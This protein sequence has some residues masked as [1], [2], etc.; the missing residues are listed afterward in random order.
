MRRDC[1]NFL[2]NSLLRGDVA[3]APMKF[4]Q[5]LKD[6]LETRDVSPT[7]LLASYPDIKQACASRSSDEIVS[8]FR[9]RAEEYECETGTMSE[10]QMYLTVV[11]LIKL[12]KR[13]VDSETLANALKVHAFPDSC[14]QVYKALGLSQKYNPLKLLDEKKRI[15][16]TFGTFDLFH[17]GHLSILQRAKAMGDVLVVGVSSDE[18]NWAKKRKR[19]CFSFEERRDIVR[20]IRCVDFVFKEESLEQKAEYLDYY[21]VDT[22]VMGDDWVGRF[23]HLGTSKRN[24]RY[25]GRTPSISTTCI[26]ELIQN[27]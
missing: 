20:N 22:L 27:A 21:D 15:V 8:E 5:I 10:A 23:D 6:F 14:F 7:E 25:L 17:V 24:V 16:M 4:R 12:F 13:H 9:A 2:R 3:V 26:V 11:A 1:C 18:L 19:A